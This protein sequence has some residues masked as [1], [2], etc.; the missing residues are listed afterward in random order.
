M[1]PAS[2]ATRA[3]RLLFLSLAAVALIPI[4][5]TELHLF[6]IHDLVGSTVPDT[7]FFEHAAQGLLQG[8]L[9]YG[10]HFLTAPDSRQ[11]FVYPPLSLLLAVPP[12]M[13]G[14]DYPLGF[15]VEML[16]LLGIGL[17]LLER[18]CRRAGIAFPVALTA[19]ALLVALGPI[20]VTRVDGLQG[21][22]LAGAALALRGRRMTLAVVLVTLAALVKETVA[23]AALPVV[24]WAIWPP[25]GERW[26]QGLGQR[27]AAVGLGLVPAAV[28]LLTFAVW[29]RGKVVG[30]AI[31]SVHRGVEIESVSATISYLLHPFLRLTSYTGRLASVQ[32]SGPQ[33]AWVAAIVAVVGVVALIW[34][35]LH[36]AQGRRCPASAIAFAIAVS[37]AATP[38]FSPQYL[39]A[40]MPVVALAAATEF[41]IR[42][43]NLLLGIGFL[44]ALLTQVEFPY[45]FSSV[46]ALD[47]LGMAIVALRN[48]SL[49]ALAVCLLRASRA[50]TSHSAMGSVAAPTLSGPS[51]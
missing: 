30:A 45:L 8:H 31:A 1:S 37:L 27:A 10:A 51:R 40:L 5:L 28:V 4:L 15:A 39:L 20:V 3:A 7:I 43:A 34:G 46:A 17:W 33:V 21:L 26:H 35:T 36:F 6:P 12:L 25:V 42:R 32:V 49:I 29:S 23:V 48:L 50:R 11:V 14:S 41:E 38:V 22:A 47:P 13:A 9:P 44:V 24:V 16:V 19:A 2:G 18:Y